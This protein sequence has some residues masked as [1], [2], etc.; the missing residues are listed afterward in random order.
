QSG[1][2]IVSH[3]SASRAANGA[4]PLLQTPAA[5]FIRQFVTET[6]FRIPFTHAD[7]SQPKTH[8]GLPAPFTWQNSL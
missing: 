7:T 8:L 2:C 3:A 1:V 5:A 4:D 6:A